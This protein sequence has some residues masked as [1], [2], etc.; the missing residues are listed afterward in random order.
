MLRRSIRTHT[1]PYKYTY[2]NPIPIST[3]EELRRSTDFKIHKVITDTLLSTETLPTT[4][5]IAPL[6]PEKPRKIRA[7]V[8]SRELESGWIGSTTRNPTN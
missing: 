8:P 6:N 4:E 3:S 1:H 2:V 7:P 5:N